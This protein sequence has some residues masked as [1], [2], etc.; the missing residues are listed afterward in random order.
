MQT[1]QKISFIKKNRIP[2]LSPLP[3]FKDH[4]FRVTQISEDGLRVSEEEYWENYYEN[5]D[6]IYEWNNG[7]LEEKPMADYQSF[8]MYRWFMALLEQY[9][10]TYPIGKVLG[11]EI[12][13]RLALPHK[14]TIRKP[15]LALIHDS[16]KNDIDFDDRNFDGIFDMCFEFLSDSKPS[17]IKRDTVVKKAE[18]CKIGVREYF[19]LDRKGNETAFYRLNRRGYYSKIL[20]KNGIIKSK[21]LPGFE[22]R[23]EDLYARPPF[24]DKINDPVYNSYIL[25]DYQTVNKQAEAERKKAEKA[26]KQAEAERK[27]A[28]KANKQAEKANKQAEAERKKAEKANKK[29]E[30]EYKR[31]EMLAAKLRELGLNPE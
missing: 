10:E 18:Y 14:T 9:L 5:S 8:L 21:V 31:A 15:D 4:E 27:K 30:A 17:E 29:A 23:I 7:V 3:A 26:N 24:I 11:L 12:G 1:L 22:F 20:Q 2:P 13:F 25:K 19:I 6:F 16:N 28:E